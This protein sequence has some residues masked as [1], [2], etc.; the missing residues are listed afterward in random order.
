[1]KYGDRGMAHHALR[2]HLEL[3]NYFSLTSSGRR[4]FLQ[5][6]I[7][8]QMLNILNDDVFASDGHANLELFNA[9]VGIIAYAL[10]LLYNLAYEKQ[11]FLLL[12]RKDMQDIC[13]N[14]QA[15]ENHTIQ[16]ASKTLLDI[17]NADDVDET[18][19]PTKLKKSY[20]EYMQKLIIESKQTVKLGVAK[21]I[22]GK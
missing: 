17:L 14:F 5:S 2:Y 22:Q 6:Y 16:F 18:N 9:E 7:I 15:S 3:L 12:K 13:S 21:D 11:F 20:I 8:D 10:M 19:E 1:M 4:Y